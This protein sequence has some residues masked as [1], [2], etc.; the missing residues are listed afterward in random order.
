MQI[1]YAHVK[2]REILGQVFGHPLRQRCYQYTLFAGGALSALTQ[3]MIDLAF[4]GADVNL[5]IHQAG[6]ANNL[7]DN[8]TARFRQL[9]WTGRR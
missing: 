2:F 4:D 3:Q 6:R 7:F 1:A 9:V 8:F 5:G